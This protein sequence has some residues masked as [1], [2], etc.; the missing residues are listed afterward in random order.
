MQWVITWAFALPEQALHSEG[1]GGTI[2][3]GSISFESDIPSCPYCDSPSFVKCGACGRATCWARE[4]FFQ[5][6][7]CAESGEVSGVITSIGV[8]GGM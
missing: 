8:V 3:V 7:W 1:Y 5:C 2:R 4:P 6:R